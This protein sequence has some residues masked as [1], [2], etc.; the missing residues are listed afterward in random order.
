MIISQSKIDIH[1]GGQMVTGPVKTENVLRSFN[2]KNNNS[3]SNNNNNN[4]NNTVII[5]NFTFHTCKSSSS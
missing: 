4:N 1:A 5:I 2:N 3:N